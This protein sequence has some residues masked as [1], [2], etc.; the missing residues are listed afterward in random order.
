MLEH[1]PNHLSNLSSSETQF[2][3]TLKRISRLASLFGVLVC[4]FPLILAAQSPTVLK[5]ESAVKIALENNLQ[6]QQAD[7]TQ[8]NAQTS[9]L[10]SK[11]NYLP[12]INGSWSGTRSFGT[13]FDNVTF[14]RVQQ[15]T[16]NSFTGLNGSITLFNGLANY[17][18]LK[19]NEYSVEASKQAKRKSENDVITN[20]ALFYLQVLFDMENTRISADR[21]KILEQQLINK[22]K[23]F[24]A[25]KTTQVELYN[26]KSQIA[27]E[28]LNQV[29]IENTLKRDKL[30]LL[31]ELMVDPFAEYTFEFPDASQYK[32]LA[33]MEP[34][35][36]IYAYAVRNMP[37]MKEQEFRIQAAQ[38]GLRRARSSYYPTLNLN[39]NLGSS[40]SSNGIFN[41]RTFQLE[42]VP[43]FD[44]L[45]RNL[46]QSISLQL[47][48]PIFNKWN[49]RNQVRNADISFRQTQLQ[50]TITQ[51]NL[52]QKIQ[53]A[54][55]DVV[56]AV[57]KYNATQE[58]LVSLNESY[59][60]AE[61]RYNA[62]LM[63]FY[64]FNENLNSRTKAE[65]ELLQ[66]QY[67]F[68]FKRKILD[69]YQGKTIK[70]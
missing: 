17:N 40:Y 54:W 3:N 34:L 2:W 69:L 66:A 26:L 32:V 7:L 61:S 29:T 55:L 12:S 13:T 58:Q 30:R 38:Y 56:A 15:A 49:V 4:L 70:F 14:S 64:S 27:S 65:S 42:T 6:L 53:Q 33:D 21:L 9:F 16:N 43:Y 1:L 22:Q 5:L 68:L 67:D 25:G 31:Q 18:T 28:K 48:I 23:E 63:D 24:D 20:V 47:N 46:N 50:Y 11:L 35:S 60:I 19:Q 57:N 44:Q 45:D 41:S 52:T 37:E 36:E 10:Q 51:N 62:G 59:K 8:E 39:A